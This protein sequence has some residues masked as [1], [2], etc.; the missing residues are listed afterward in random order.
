MLWEE[1]NRK[2]MEERQFFIPGT[3]DVFMVGLAQDTPPHLEKIDGGARWVLFHA[4]SGHRV[5]AMNDIGQVSFLANWLYRQL[6]KDHWVW[7]EADTEKVRMCLDPVFEHGL[8]TVGGD[9]SG[10]QSARRFEIE[11]ETARSIQ[12]VLDYGFTNH[13]DEEEPEEGRLLNRL[14]R[15]GNAKLGFPR[16]GFGYADAPNQN[17]KL[18]ELRITYLKQEMRKE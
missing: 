2:A 10:Y 7:A 15:E 17:K 18:L 4:K 1:K 9:W 8:K 6:P 5:I 13:P 14:T 16:P 11:D 3:D 12:L